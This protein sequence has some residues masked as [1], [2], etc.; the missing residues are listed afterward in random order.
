[1]HEG[2]KILV[3]RRDTIVDRINMQQLKSATETGHSVS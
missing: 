1:M 3:L 2:A